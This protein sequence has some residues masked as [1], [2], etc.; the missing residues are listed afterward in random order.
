MLDLFLPPKLA[1]HLLKKLIV[2]EATLGSSILV[3]IA[4]R[5][6]LRRVVVDVAV[7]ECY[8]ARQRLLVWSREVVRAAVLQQ[9][10]HTS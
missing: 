7:F 4:T 1:T 5:Q 10:R 3:K 8:R 9:Q 6:A 2:R